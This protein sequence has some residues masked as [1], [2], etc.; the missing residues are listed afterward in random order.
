MC[1]H[2]R[3]LLRQRE[4]VLI[5]NLTPRDC[6]V[7]EADQIDG[8]I[9]WDSFRAKVNE[10]DNTLTIES[11]QPAGTVFM[12]NDTEDFPLYV[13]TITREEGSGAVLR[14]SAIKG[15]NRG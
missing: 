13:E 11:G 4:T 9:H 7:N 15:G 8:D 10:A 12:W 14:Q 1:F 6:Y 3:G 5:T 2:R